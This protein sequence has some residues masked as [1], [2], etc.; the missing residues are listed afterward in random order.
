MGP[1]NNSQQG[2]IRKKRTL[3]DFVI[4]ILMWMVYSVYTR[5]ARRNM[6]KTP[7]YGDI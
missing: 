7:Y 1:D 2:D 3:G 4:V 5:F 6:D